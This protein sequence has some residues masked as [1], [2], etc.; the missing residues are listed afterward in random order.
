MVAQFSGIDAA[1]ASDVCMHCRL[2]RLSSASA[3]NQEDTVADDVEL[4]GV[5]LRVT[6]NKLGEAT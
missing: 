4:H 5:V 3:G 6:A 1:G 2:K